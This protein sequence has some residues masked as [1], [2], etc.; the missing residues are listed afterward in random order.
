MIDTEGNVKTSGTVTAAEVNAGSVRTK[1]LEIQTASTI[2]S[3][4]AVL[5]TS[6]GVVT[7]KAGKTTVDVSTSAMG[8]KSLV[9]T[10][11]DAPIAVGTKRKD[12]D[13]FT[14]ILSEPAAQDVR[15]NWWIIN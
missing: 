14:I 9:F 5:T 11:P 1:K 6:A 15:V 2:S 3:P 7:I 13:T 8:A 12:T 10:T 4:S